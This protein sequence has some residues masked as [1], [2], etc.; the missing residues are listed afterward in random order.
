MHIYRIILTLVIVVAEDGTCLFVYVVTD[1]AVTHEVKM[2][3]RTAFKQH[4]GLHPEDITGNAIKLT[5]L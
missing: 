5:F 4:A 2:S 3:N 1:D